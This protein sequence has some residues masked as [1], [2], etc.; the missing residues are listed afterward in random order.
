MAISF[1]NCISS[2]FSS[3]NLFNFDI[4]IKEDR[5][6]DGALR[7]SFVSIIFVNSFTVDYKLEL[8]RMYK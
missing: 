1:A 4:N 6:E 3:I 5:A 7:N 2:Q 8:T